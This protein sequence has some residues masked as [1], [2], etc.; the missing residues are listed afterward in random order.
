MEVL[1]ADLKLIEQELPQGTCQVDLVASNLFHWEVTLA[2]P[3]GT[4]YKGGT[5]RFWLWFPLEYPLQKPRL[6]CLTPMYHCN[7]DHN[8]SVGLDMDQELLHLN[9]LSQDTDAPPST[10]NSAYCI[11]Q[12]LLSLFA[13][14]VP[15]NALVPDAGRLF[16]ANRQE[17]NR[18]AQEWTI[19]YAC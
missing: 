18:K 7:I 4:P 19:Q 16:L 11:V 9:V 3:E 6:K 17:Y 10:R 1:K 15:E 13:A 8:G 2:G 5:F 14:P 12:A